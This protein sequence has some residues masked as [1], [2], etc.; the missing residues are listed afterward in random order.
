MLFTSWLRDLRSTLAPGRTERSH[1]R[2]RPGRGPA[3]R[4]LVLER[5]EDRSLPSC[6]VSLAPS[7]AAPQLVGERI[8]WTAT[9]ADCGT[10]PVY[11]FSAAPHGGAFHVV[12]DFSPANAFA[13]TPMQE[14]AYD[15]EVIVKD[16]YQATETTTA[17]A[18]DAVA[19]RA[20]GSEAVITPTLNPLVALYSAPPSSAGSEFVQF[21]LAG[22]SSV[23]RNTNTL[24]VVPGKSTN[25]FVAGMLPNTTYEMR[26]VR[27]DGTGSEPLLF[28]TGGI[29]AN[30]TIP[31]ITVQQPPVPGS[32]LDQDMVFHQ[33]SGSTPARPPLI[34][35]NLAGQ[36]MW[37]YDLSD[38]GFTLVRVGQSLVPGGTL[39]VGGADRY[40]PVAG[41]TNVLR[42]IDLAGNPVRETSVAALN[43]ELAA[44]GHGVINAFNHDVQR[45]ADG[46]T[47]ALA[48]TE[49][50][51]TING[52]PTNYIGEMVLVLDPD[53]QVTWA[54][55]AFDHLDVNRGPVLGEVVLP[56][57]PEP[58]ASV[59]LLPAVDWLHVNAVA[60]SPADG[61]L[62]LSVRHQ[63][64]VIKIDYRN[65]A[66][67][68]HVVWRLGQGG[69]FALASAGPNAWFS[70][71]HNAHYI[72]DHTLIL[73]DNGNTR[74][75]TDSTAN[76][77]GQ[78]WTLDENNMTATP[79]LNADL[80]NYSGR[81]GSAQRLSNG[82][83]SFLSGAVGFPPPS[84][85]GQTI[86]VLPDGT[87]SYVLKFASPEYRSYRLRTLYEGIDD[88]LAGDAR[89]VESVVVNDGSAQRS[90]VNSITVTFGGSVVLEPGAI[91]LRRQDGSLVNAEFN[92]SL[93]SGKTVAVLTFAGPEFVGGSLVDGSYTLTVRAD[94][95]HDRWGR[96]LDGNGDGAAGGDRV[97][98]FFR[99]F[100]DSDGDG[101]VDGQDRDRFR[102]A[103]GRTAADAGYLWYF[104]FDGD[105]DVDGLDNGQFNRRFGQY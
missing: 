47:V 82:N 28:T 103:S 91:E 56:G 54:W 93:L 92:I 6:T 12:R 16:G 72:D 59:P 30:L 68:G 44:L 19:S 40:T 83:Y 45:L 77:R 96:E 29:P 79:V 65:G 70:H 98:G 18:V 52:T 49:R 95:V 46:T 97:D 37:Y 24:A 25:F 60:L 20:T 80:G 90:M 74:R 23:W 53:F 71:Q 3:T 9:A 2:Q 7:E 39:L 48:L 64:W 78:V 41:A 38:A 14:G 73:F 105:G 104:D 51:V 15:I 36:A 102:S 8:T 4:R 17:V 57:A 99:L 31:A 85:I 76:S 55:D 69:D 100:G 75:A 32:D 63:D 81:L 34:A 33:G 61:N 62:I 10:A 43:A 86:E 13:W 101:D 50:T 27:S 21:R 84:Q 22:D 87:K 66:G 42:E 35:T 5:L 88:A 67:D 11:Q 1:R 94:L 89:K 26:D 58:T